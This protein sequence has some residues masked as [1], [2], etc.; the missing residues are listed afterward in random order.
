MDIMLRGRLSFQLEPISV[1][2]PR[3]N[4]A[5]IIR[6]EY[7]MLYSFMRFHILAFQTITYLF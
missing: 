7:A 6:N 4:K 3:Q 5:D 2:Y 1:S